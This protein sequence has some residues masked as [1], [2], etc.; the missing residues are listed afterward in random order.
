MIFISTLKTGICC[1][2]GPTFGGMMISGQK[3]AHLALKALGMPNAVDGTLVGNLHPELILA[4]AES[5]ET[6]EA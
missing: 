1:V 3:A 4:A 6:A 2:Q 5:G